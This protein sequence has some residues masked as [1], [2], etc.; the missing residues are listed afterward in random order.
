MLIEADATAVVSCQDDQI[1]VQVVICRLL[2]VEISHEL[3]TSDHRLPF[4]L[5]FQAV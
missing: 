1:L 2:N 3:T 5:L 4:V